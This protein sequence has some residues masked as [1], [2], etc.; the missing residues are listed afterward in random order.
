[1]LR[2][3][4]MAVAS[5]LLGW[6]LVPVSWTQQASDVDGH[7]FDQGNGRGL[8]NLEVKLTP[9][10]SANLPIRLAS[11]DQNG[12]FR[13]SQLKPSRYLLEVSQGANLLYRVQVDAA[14]QTHLEIPLQRR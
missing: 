3:F 9:P 5:V 6:M 14:A 8:E 10:T 2:H 7:V 11:T 4:R 13:F 1:M 12:Q